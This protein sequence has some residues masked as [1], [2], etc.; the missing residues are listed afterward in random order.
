MNANPYAPTGA[1]SSRKQQIAASPAHQNHLISPL[2]G[3]NE[4][5]SQD[6]RFHPPVSAG[7]MN[8]PYVS[9]MMQ[10]CV[11]AFMHGLRHS[12][13]IL[14]SMESRHVSTCHVR[15]VT[16]CLWGCKHRLWM[17]LLMAEVHIRPIHRFPRHPDRFE[18]EAGV[19][20]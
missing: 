12:H 4:V 5:T 15:H 18:S 14:Q 17:Q 7:K 19:Q 9:P 10:V 2:L 8:N 3:P 11:R 1:D 20:A 6:Q 13:T 16:R